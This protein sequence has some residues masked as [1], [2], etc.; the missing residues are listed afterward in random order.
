MRELCVGPATDSPPVIVNLEGV[1]VVVCVVVGDN[2]V[3]Y[4]INSYIK[5]MCVDLYVYNVVELFAIRTPYTV[6]I[7]PYTHHTYIKCK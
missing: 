3:I 2:T 7:T 1:C 6:H 4:L 5:V